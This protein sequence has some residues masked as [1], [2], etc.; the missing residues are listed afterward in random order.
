MRH[1]RRLKQVTA[2]SFDLDDTLYANQPIMAT[3]YQKMTDFF[4][5]QL[6]GQKKY[7]FDFWWHYRD[8]AIALNPEL[9]HD[10]AAV[11]LESYFLGIKALGYS[12]QDAQNLA[13]KAFDYFVEQRSNFTVSQSSHQLLADLAERFPLI[14]ISNGNVDCQAIGLSQYFTH[15]FHAGNGL[16]QKPDSKMFTLAAKSLNI[17]AEQFLHVGDCGNAD[18]RGAILAGFQSA[19]LPQYGIG[20]PLSL[21]P[22]IE[23]ADISELRCLL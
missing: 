22:N 10:V 6:G 18:I 1:F 17:E 12:Q 7:D 3:A 15:I 20:K 23:L 8:Q 9:V 13:T 14:A 2:L 4:S 16:K 11:R 5:Q 21:L 19:W